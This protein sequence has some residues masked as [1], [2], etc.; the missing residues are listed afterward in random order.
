MKYKGSNK[1]EKMTIEEKLWLMIG[2]SGGVMIG[3]TLTLIF[4]NI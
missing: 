4:I 2:L 3:I 1:R